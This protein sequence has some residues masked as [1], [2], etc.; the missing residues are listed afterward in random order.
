MTYLKLALTAI[1][2]ILAITQSHHFNR[3]TELILSIG[4]PVLSCLYWFV[5]YLKQDND[6]RN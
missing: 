4:V 1:I 6:I 3:Q 2:C 5:V